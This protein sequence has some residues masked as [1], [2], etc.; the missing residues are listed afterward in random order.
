M[1]KLENL[2]KRL[3]LTDLDRA[4]ILLTIDALKEKGEAKVVRYARPVRMLAIWPVF[5][6]TFIVLDAISPD[7]ELKY[8]TVQNFLLDGILVDYGI[9]SIN[10]TREKITEKKNPKAAEVE[11][12]FDFETAKT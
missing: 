12:T 10:R 7:A 3:A 9:Y 6:G 5:L 11:T 2:V 1:K 8:L 4:K